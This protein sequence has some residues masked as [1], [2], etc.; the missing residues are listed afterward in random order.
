MIRLVVRIWLLPLLLRSAA[1]SLA[2][3]AC[4][5]LPPGDLQI[6][7][8]WRAIGRAQALAAELEEAIR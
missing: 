2:L 7:L 3:Q 1:A 4:R 5:L 6:W 8:T